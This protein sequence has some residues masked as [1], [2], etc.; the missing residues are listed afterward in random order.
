MLLFAHTFVLLLLLY[1]IWNDV[2]HL[3]QFSLFE[4]SM[5]LQYSNI[6]LKW[7][8]RLGNHVLYVRPTYVPLSFSFYNVSFRDCFISYCIVLSFVLL[9]LIWFCIIPYYIIFLN[10][11]RLSFNCIGTYSS[12]QYGTVMYDFF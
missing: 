5:S 6:F 12:E 11:I 7:C 4:L 9:Y 1:I 10:C 2:F 8:D 3:H